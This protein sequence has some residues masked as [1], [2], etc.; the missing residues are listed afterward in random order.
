MEVK[1]GI[2]L[3]DSEYVS[4][5]GSDFAS[6]AVVPS[7]LTFVTCAMAEFVANIKDSITVAHTFIDD[8]SIKTQFAIEYGDRTFCSQRLID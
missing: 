8:G 2:S 6:T 5:C 1:T 3:L 4:I 7:G